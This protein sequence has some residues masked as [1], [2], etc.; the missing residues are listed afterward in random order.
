MNR[1]HTLRRLQR[2]LR[3]WQGATLLSIALLLTGASVAGLTG[4]SLRINADG[5]DGDKVRVNING[6]PAFRIEHSAGASRVFVDAAAGIVSES[7]RLGGEGGPRILTGSD[8]PTGDISA[9]SGSVYLRT[10]GELYLLV[11]TEWKLVE[12][13]E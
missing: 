2:S 3:I 12:V 1:R 5:A 13:A 8:D 9:P 6:Q 7:L 11:G 10:T 4:S